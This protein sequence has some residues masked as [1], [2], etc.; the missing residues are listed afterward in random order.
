MSAGHPHLAPYIHGPR[1]PAKRGYIVFAAIVVALVALRL[2]L[3]YLARDY[4]N[5]K[6]SSNADYRGHVDEIRISL[7]RGAYQL[8]GLRIEK[9]HGGVPVPFLSCPDIDISLEWKALLRGAIVAKI[10]AQRPVMNL[11]K[12]ATQA[13]TQMKVDKIWVQTAKDLVPLTVN[14]LAIEDGALHYRDFGSKPKVDIVISK[15]GLVATNLRTVEEKGE[16]LPAR[17]QVQ[18]TCF[19]SGT[20]NLQMAL[21]P[22]KPS[23]TF[24]LKESL[25][26]VQLVKL[27]DILEAYADLKVK[28]GEFGL[29]TEVA[30]KDGS[31]L[32]Y[33]KP[34]IRDLEVDKGGKANRTLLRKLWAEI[35]AAAGWLF[36][37]S[38]QVQL[39]TKI[40]VEGTFDKAEVGVWAAVGGLL[41]NA[42][43]Q[44]LI[45]ALD[46]TIHIGQVKPSKRAQAR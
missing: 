44:A 6:L 21:A 23:P 27:N 42:F 11:V 33:T 29:Y 18:A 36:S 2:S 24:E 34:I 12:G 32:G 22:L 7:W 1:R 20:L 9:P 4:V 31:F 10:L 15:I 17:V 3:P 35:A 39:A 13:K 8:E 30:A 40:P 28:K 45:P 25:R 38:E 14:R 5:R 16:L 37:N 43:I 41:K 26:G 46:N 19:E